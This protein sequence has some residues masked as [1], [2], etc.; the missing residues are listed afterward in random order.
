M[1]DRQIE[2]YNSIKERDNIII[3]L[4]GEL[5]ILKIQIENKKENTKNEN[6]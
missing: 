3:D 1:N 5:M 2:Y 4:K 6:K